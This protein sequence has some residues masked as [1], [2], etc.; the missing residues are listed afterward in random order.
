M[1][2]VIIL[3]YFI[4]LTSFLWLLVWVSVVGTR[5]PVLSSSFLLL[6]FGSLIALCVLTTLGVKTTSVCVDTVFPTTATQEGIVRVLFE[7][8][9][10]TR[11]KSGQYVFV[12]IARSGR[13]LLK[14]ANW[15]PYNISEVFRVN[16][17][18]YTSVEERIIDSVTAQT[19]RAKRNLLIILI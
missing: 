13:K 6:L 16:N 19:K 14:Y 17:N 2:V 12:I 1:F 7:H 10:M 18:A 15:H 3:K 9:A 8:P 5:L 4:T 11:F